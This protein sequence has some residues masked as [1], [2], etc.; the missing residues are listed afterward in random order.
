M[1]LNCDARCEHCGKHGHRVDTCSSRKVN[2]MNISSGAELRIMSSKLEDVR[3]V[4]MS[5]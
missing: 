1:N 3:L 2:D 4:M 5:E